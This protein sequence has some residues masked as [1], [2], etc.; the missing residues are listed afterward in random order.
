MGQWDNTQI[1]I[2]GGCYQPGH[3]TCSSLD[4]TVCIVCVVCLTEEEKNERKKTAM[5]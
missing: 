4:F 3:D 5:M 1:D 2:N